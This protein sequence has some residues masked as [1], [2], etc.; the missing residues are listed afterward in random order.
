MGQPGASMQ[1][2]VWSPEVIISAE[3]PHPAP[4]SLNGTLLSFSPG[5]TCLYEGESDGGDAGGRGRGMSR[6]SPRH[7]KAKAKVA[8]PPPSL[9]PHPTRSL[10]S[11]AYGPQAHCPQRNPLPTTP[12]R[13]ACSQHPKFT[14]LHATQSASGKKTRH[15]KVIRGSCPECTRFMNRFPGRIEGGGGGRCWPVF[16]SAHESTRL[17]ELLCR[18]AAADAGES[19]PQ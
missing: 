16:I 2:F 1:S 5:S 15:N 12:P 8:A 19:A 17:P 7:F 6:A 10:Q 9:S 14:T 13:K 11:T 4:A 3:W 18:S